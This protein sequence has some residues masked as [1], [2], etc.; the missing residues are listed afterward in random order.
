MIKKIPIGFLL[1]SMVFTFSL[2]SCNKDENK[3]LISKHNG[4]ESHKAREDC[5]QCHRSGGEGPGIFTV[6]GSVYK[7]DLAS[8]LP[9]VTVELFSA[10]EG[11]TGLV[12][13]IE[14]DAK[15]NFYTT[16]PLDLSSGYDTWVIGTDQLKYTMEAEITSGSCNSC[17]GSSVDRIWAK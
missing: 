6:A 8:A 2:I 4:T 1:F 11:A 14:V 9:N 5:T 17:H 12:Y 16:D 13:S 7:E 10:L 15:G 3:T